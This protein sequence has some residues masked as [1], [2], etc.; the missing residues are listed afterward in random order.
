LCGA[1]RCVKVDPTCDRQCLGQLECNH[2]YCGRTLAGTLCVTNSDDV[3][4]FQVCAQ[5]NDRT[6]TDELSPTGSESLTTT[7]STSDSATASP[8]RSSS[9][10]SSESESVSASSTLTES[11]S[12][13]ESLSLSFT[14]T[15]A[16]CHDHGDGNHSH[17]AGM[18]DDLW[19]GS[20]AGTHYTDTEG[21]HFNEDPNDV[22]PNGK[23]ARWHI[24]H[25]HCPGHQ[26]IGFCCVSTGECARPHCAANFLGNTTGRCR[27][28]YADYKLWSQGKTSAAKRHMSHLAAGGKGAISDAP[29]NASDETPSPP[30]N[31]KGNGGGGGGAGNAANGNGNGNNGVGNGNG[32]SPALNLGPTIDCGVAL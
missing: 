28:P 13:T 2:R 23:P 17:D 9:E 25:L 16:F 30:S 27:F 19:S 29:A 3:K 12:S 22:G 26:C 5:E 21:D 24:P 14:L 18:D 31:G 11:A 20:G 32:N 4:V 10:S 1:A 8:S 6:I 15:P 7:D